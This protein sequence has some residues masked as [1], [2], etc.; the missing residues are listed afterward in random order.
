MDALLRTWE[1]VQRG[2]RKALAR[3][4]RWHKGPPV[5]VTWWRKGFGEGKQ[6]ETLAQEDYEDERIGWCKGKGPGLLE[7]WMFDD[8][9]E[10]ARYYVHR[11]VNKK[12][13][14]HVNPQVLAYVD[15]GYNIVFIPDSL[16]AA[17]Y[18]LFALELA[19][20][21]PQATCAYKRCPTRKQTFV[22]Q[23]TNQIY[24]SGKCRR[25]DSYYRVKERRA[26]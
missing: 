12:L 3:R 26:P 20:G 2:D 11:E 21:I 13:R 16:L 24:C 19:G 18:V 6:F 23:R 15:T 8:T 10:P 4:V 5:Q 9:V 1:Q 22:P 17:L 14:G 25:N 7:R